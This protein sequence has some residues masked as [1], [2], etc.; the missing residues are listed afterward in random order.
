[1][2]DTTR[3]FKV[4]QDYNNGKIDKEK[5]LYTVEKQVGATPELRNYLQKNP[6]SGDFSGVLKQA[7]VINKDS[8]TPVAPVPT[9]DVIYHRGTD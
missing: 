1:M 9:L 5:F 3:L 7:R 8:Q 4:Y 6:L 2:T